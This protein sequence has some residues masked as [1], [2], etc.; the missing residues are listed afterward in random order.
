MMRI[1]LFRNFSNNLV[2]VDRIQ[3]RN[4]HEAD[5]KSGYNRNNRKRPA[6]ELIREGLKDLKTE[7]RLWTDEWKEHLQ[8]D[9]VMGMPIPGEVDAQWTFNSNSSFD[10]WIVTS[11]RDHG[12]GYSTCSLALSPTGK[13]LF[14]G[15]LSTQVVKNGKVKKAGY[16]NM[17]SEPPT[18]S[19][20]RDDYHNWSLYT[21]IVLRVRG[22]GRSYM[23][24]VGSAGYFDVNWH[25][26]YNYILHTRGGPHWQVSRIPFSK[27]FLASK[28]RIQDRQCPLPLD[29]ISSFGISAGD[30]IN[31]PF[32]LE[33][34]YIGLEY[35]PSHTE[36]TAYE[37]YRTPKFYSGY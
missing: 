17:K 6:K 37:L 10:K 33:I 34:D 12:E 29:R 7:I 2:F 36:K 31:G 1:F 19:F 22:D 21:H 32:R 9:P 18:K 20:K 23:M 25:D 35:D 4:F 26:M 15:V 5:R 13:G 14:S 28:G 16:C 8:M 24:N 27:F 3:C 11:D 30:G